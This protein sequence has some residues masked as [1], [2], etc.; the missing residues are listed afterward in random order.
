[1]PL[2]RSSAAR[3]VLEDADAILFLERVVTV[4]T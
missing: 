1:M 3:R 4:V 2:G